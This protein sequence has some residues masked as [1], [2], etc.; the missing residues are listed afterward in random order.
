VPRRAHRGR[1]YVELAEWQWV[2]GPECDQYR[3]SGAHRLSSLA[4]PHG[5]C[6][7]SPRLSRPEMCNAPPCRPRTHLSRCAL[8][9]PFTLREDETLAIGA[10]V[11][12][13]R[14]ARDLLLERVVGKDCTLDRDHLDVG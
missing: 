6:A 9:L 10:I 11:D 12:D 8:L 5:W 7:S 3:G 1:W 4:C 14:D 13:L 2:V